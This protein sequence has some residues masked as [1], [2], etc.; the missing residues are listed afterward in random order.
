MATEVDGEERLVGLAHWVEGRPLD[1]VLARIDDVERIDGYFEAIGRLAAGIHNE[2]ST[3]TPP[4]EF[5]RRAWDADGLVGE[6]AALGAFLGGAGLLR[7]GV[8]DSGASASG[9]S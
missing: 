5:T 6:V 4:P 9:N 8:P 1:R 3:W 2:A 7:R